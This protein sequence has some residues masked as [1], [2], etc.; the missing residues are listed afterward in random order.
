MAGGSRTTQ[1]TTVDPEV[2][3]LNRLMRL[4]IEQL[5][6]LVGGQ[7]GAVAA[8]APAPA[9][10][11]GRPSPFFPSSFR[12]Q[13]AAPPAGGTG[14]LSAITEFRPLAVPGAGELDILGQIARMAQQPVDVAGFRSENMARFF[15][16]M[17]PQATQGFQRAFESTV[18][19]GITN[20][21]I[22]S[23]MGRSGALGEA[24][25][26]AGA[27]FITPAV[28]EAFR[29]A[30]AQAGALP[31][32]G[33]IELQRLPA[34]LSAL[35]GPRIAQ[36][37]EESRRGETLLSLLSGF[38]QALGGGT[39]TGRVSNQPNIM[40]ALGTGALALALK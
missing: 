9:S 34:A 35:E 5:M 17:L 4:D 26:G 8:P 14:A 22:A 12:P 6:R 18:A 37:T 32:P 23:G 13:P 27:Q 20:R 30:Q 39:T 25:A 7:G 24:L 15:N 10:P 19:P 21:M 11:L 1:T 36:L 38:P 31:I 33:A 28:T 16:E 29:G 2:S 40:Q 3:A